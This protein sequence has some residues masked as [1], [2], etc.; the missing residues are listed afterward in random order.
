MSGHEHGD[1]PLDSL[2]FHVRL[3]TTTVCNLRCRQCFHSLY[4][5]WGIPYPRYEMPPALF[6]K[7]L[8]ELQ[9][10]IEYLGLSCSAEPFANS[11]FHRYL[12]IA[13]QHAPTVFKWIVTNGLLLDEEMARDLI[14]TGVN[15]LIISIDGAR[16]QSYNAI[17]RGGD[18][19]RLMDRVDLINRVKA[20]MGSELPVVVFNVTLM[21]GN[22][23]ELPLF[24]DLAAEKKLPELTFQHLVPI[25]GLDLK[26]EAL[27]FEN[28]RKVREVFD[29]T[30]KRAGELGVQLANLCEIPSSLQ[31]LR[32]RLADT[33]RRWLRPRNGTYCHVVWESVVINPGGDLFPCYCWGSEP[34]MG[35]LQKQTFR[36]IWQ[37][38]R[39]QRL[40]DELC[41]RFPLRP[42]CRDCSHL[43]RGR[44][45]RRTFREQVFHPELVTPVLA[46]GEET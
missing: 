21:R 40:R 27:F 10:H 41:G 20:E 25:R 19:D 8:D 34:P 2:R 6:E 37:T 38:E 14:T 31:G 17:R 15:R 18:F 7:I 36:E 24:V 29:R 30:R 26:H 5:M 11:D 16:R 12:A 33:A 28:R 35:N 3:D 13:R 46:P 42:C 22:L 39:Y 45:T 1:D 32:T 44:L 4:R 43:G 9:G 23:D